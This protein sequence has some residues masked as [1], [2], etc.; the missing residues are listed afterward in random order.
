MLRY[1]GKYDQAEDGM[2]G[3]E[4]EELYKRIVWGAPTFDM[5]VE[6]YSDIY[7]DASDYK[8]GEVYTRK[9]LELASNST[10]VSH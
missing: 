10:S 5:A 2:R 3:R 4:Y 1:R 7:W 9:H 6:S 8:G